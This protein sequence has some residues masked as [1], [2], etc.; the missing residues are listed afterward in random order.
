M[1]KLMLSKGK[2]VIK[3]IIVCEV[4]DEPVGQ[5]EGCGGYFRE[6]EYVYCDGDGKHYHLDCKP[7]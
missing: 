6:D 2:L 1:E 7:Y 5:C 3:Q 4:C